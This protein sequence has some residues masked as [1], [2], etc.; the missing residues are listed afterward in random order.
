MDKK[1]KYTDLTF[2]TNEPDNAIL[3]RFNRVLLN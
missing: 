1:T 3:D 2:F